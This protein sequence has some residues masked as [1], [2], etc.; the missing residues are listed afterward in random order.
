MRILVISDLFPSP[1]QPQKGIFVLRQLQQLAAM[2]NE[3]L[4][5]RA[6]PV[7]PP[8]SRKW[9]QY[10]SL[11]SRYTFEGISVRV[12]RAVMPPRLIGIELLRPQLLGRLR[13]TIAAFRPDVIHAQCLIPAGLLAVDLGVPTVVTAHGSDAYDL[14]WRRQDLRRAAARVAVSADIVVGVSN[15]IADQVRKLGRHKIV[16]IFN[17]ADERLFHPAERHEAKLALGISPG[18]PVIVFP[19]GLSRAKGFVELVRA[20]SGLRDLKP[21][22]VLAGDD[23]G[24]EGAQRVLEDERLDY[25]VLGMVS[26]SELAK[27]FQAAE[28]ITLPSHREGLPAVLCEAMLA[29]RAVVATSVGGIGEIVADGTTGCLVRSEDPDALAK[30]LRRILEDAGFR[31]SLETAAYS[32]AINSLTW[33]INAMQYEAVYKESIARHQCSVS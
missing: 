31:A 2:G 20:A 14:P 11:P 23:H 19:G 26:Q 27:A 30:A 29:G 13:E 15:F 4:V 7:A 5:V 3:L 12:L 32:F 9:N 16:T 18:Q 1:A 8:F 24:R 6:V 22:L 17:G 28:V 33:R 10:R 21:M 25:R